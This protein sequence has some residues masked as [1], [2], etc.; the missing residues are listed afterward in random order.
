M[1]KKILIILIIAAGFIIITFAVGVYYFLPSEDKV[2]NF[3]INNPEKTSILLVRNDSII[4]SR[5][6]DKIMPLA[7][8]VKI[9][10]A[11]EYAEQCALGKLNPDELVLLSDLE[12][13]H[14][15]N[16]DGG[17]H[18]RWLKSVKHKVKEDKISIREIAKGMIEFS[19]NANAEWL[20]NKLGVQKV[21]AR[22]D[23]LG[24]KNHTKIYNIVS[25][26]FVG[27]ELFPGLK[28]KELEMKLKE[29]SMDDYISATERIHQKLLTDTSYKKELG[30][31]GMNIQRIWSDRLPSSTVSDYVSIMKKINSRNN[32]DQITQEYLDEVMEYVLDNPANRERLEHCGMK[33]G[34]TP[35]VLTKALY[36]TDKKG[37]K[38]EL[39]YFMNDLNILEMISLQM[40]MNEFELKILS[41]KEFR[42]KIKTE[43]T[44]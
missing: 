8:T 7:S 39:A 1:F 27:K 16:T 20:L 2:L 34:S 10:L 44:Q 24:I 28:G 43:L 42:D 17:A 3:I 33:G 12:K 21:N 30:D 29:L 37:N 41:S 25:A 19:S 6:I 14:V 5:N 26:L 4:A 36:A 22:I 15:P 9:I 40:S 32:F 23:S 11:I 38:T 18:T 31:L 13:F 35:F